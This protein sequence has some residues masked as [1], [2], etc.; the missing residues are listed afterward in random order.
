M[1]RCVSF[2]GPLP[3]P[4]NG[5]SSVCGMMLERLR[6]RMPVEVFNRA[7][8]LRARALGT[9]RQLIYPARYLGLCIGRRDVVLYLAL[10]GGRGQLVDLIYVLISKLFRRP[11]FV[12]HHSF[13]Y[14]NSPSWLNRCV[15]A[16]VRNA[17]HIVLS[18]NMG[19]ALMR[20]YGLNPGVV[21]VLSNAAFY[22]SEHE[23]RAPGNDSAPLQLGFLSN[24]TFE[25]G[26]VEFFRILEKL[27]QGGID[28]RAHIA[29]PLAPDARQTFDTLLGAANDVE[30][31]GPVY[32]G[33]KEQ[34]YRQLDVFL[35]PTN[36]ANE[37]EPL[38][39]YEAMRQGV[40]VIACDRGAI[41]EMLCNG[42]GLAFSREHI[43]E[44]A[45]AHIAKFNEDRH[46]LA[47]AKR[48]SMQQ[49]ERVGCASKVALENLLACMQG[50]HE[51]A[52]ISP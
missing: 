10:S 48:M 22:D 51:P 19:E 18:P 40:H 2:V 16:L 29:G 47:A 33:Q 3:P 41:A 50:T 26:I 43:V 45:A 12:H 23:A 9:L 13:V 44:A 11:V 42:A 15:F 25:K 27:N 30:Y 38:V 36:Y 1:T 24:I 20:V 32:G 34:F 35:F 46:A 7:P 8:K 28:Y 14:I 6:T 4:V 39:I 21:S 37:A 49:A 17:T 5:F 52:R 31:V